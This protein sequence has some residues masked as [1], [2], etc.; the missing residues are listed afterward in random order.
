MN[1]IYS[2]VVKKFVG[3]TKRLRA[4]NK[5]EIAPTHI[6]FD[7]FESDPVRV[8]ISHAQ[9]DFSLRLRFEIVEEN[10]IRYLRVEVSSGNYDRYENMV[11]NRKFITRLRYEFDDV[12][13]DTLMDVFVVTINAI[14][15]NRYHEYLK[16]PQPSKAKLAG[17]ISI[18]FSAL[19]LFVTPTNFFTT[20]E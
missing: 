2:E 18:L 3:V 11:H 8:F 19:S 16:S 5:I 20:S 6:T 9:D 15:M 7:E 4:E 10:D 14:C 12:M 13:E 1:N 17:A